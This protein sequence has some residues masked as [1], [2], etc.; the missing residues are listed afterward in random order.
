LK[1][2]Q[3]I[4]SDIYNY[5]KEN[6]KIDISE[7]GQI[8]AAGTTTIV[9]KPKR[10]INITEIE[11][12]V[13]HLTFESDKFHYL[14]TLFSNVN[15]IKIERFHFKKVSNLF[16]E[17]FEK[18]EYEGISFYFT[19]ELN[20]ERIYSERLEDA[21]LN[22]TNYYWSQKFSFHTFPKKEILKKI[23]EKMGLHDKRTSI[24]SSY[25]R[26]VFSSIKKA[27]DAIEETRNLFDFRLDLH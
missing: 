25:E 11:N 7:F 27:F 3:W 18:L 10:E 6:M 5:I 2:S 17:D 4:Y 12:P 13:L 16:K 8:I 26:K 19:T 23:A 15:E 1:E 14:N 20:N 9:L 22:T 21:M 24:I